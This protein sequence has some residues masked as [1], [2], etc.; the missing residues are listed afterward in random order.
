MSETSGRNPH[1]YVP[2]AQIPQRP[3][4]DG[5]G[6]HPVIHESIAA[7]YNHPNDPSLPQTH[8]SIDERVMNG[9]N[10][11]EQHY[12]YSDAPSSTPRTAYPNGSLATAAQKWPPYFQGQY[13]SPTGDHDQPRHLQHN[14]SHLNPQFSPQQ[15]QHGWESTRP[16]V[17]RQHSTSSHDPSFAH[18]HNMTHPP[19]Y[20]MTTPSYN[21]PPHNPNPVEPNAAAPSPPNQY[22]SSPRTPQVSQLPTTNGLP[23]SLGTRTSSSARVVPSMP[24]PAMNG[25]HQHQHSNNIHLSSDRVMFVEPNHDSSARYSPLNT[26]VSARRPSGLDIRPDSGGR[27]TNPYG[28]LTPVNH[29]NSFY[30]SSSPLSPGSKVTPMRNDSGSVSAGGHFSRGYQFPPRDDGYRYA[31]SHNSERRH[32]EDHGYPTAPNQL[33]AQK[34]GPPMEP[35]EQSPRRN[36]N[37][38][39]GRLHGQSNG[40]DSIPDDT[41][42]EDIKVETMSRTGSISPTATRNV[43]QRVRRDSMDSAGS[44]ESAKDGSKKRGGP[45][46]TDSNGRQHYEEDVL[47]LGVENEIPPGWQMGTGKK[48]LRKL[49]P[50]AK[51]GLSVFPEWGLTSAGKARQRLPKACASCR[52]KKIKCV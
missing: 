7:S 16:I 15:T 21:R 37:M 45:V 5:N 10:S 39:N 32:S 19:P 23:A 13:S 4:P 27:V 42:E 49:L 31:D 26:S 3:V 47:P 17:S 30:P 33:G 6:V 25:H 50:V 14:V 29:Q 38:L 12:H 28:S 24:A 44:T 35:R 18:P 8:G 9:H 52:T 22:P 40:H 20:S 48:C 51:D 43:I 11:G 2:A 41:D 36:S 46:F 34:R 1:P